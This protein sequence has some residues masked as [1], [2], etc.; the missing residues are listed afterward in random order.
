[1]NFHLRSKRRDNFRHPTFSSSQNNVNDE[2]EKQSRSN[3]EQSLSMNNVGNSNHK[4][5]YRKATLRD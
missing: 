1:M 4:L 5:I 3:P 2:V